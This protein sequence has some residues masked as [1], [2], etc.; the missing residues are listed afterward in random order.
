MKVDVGYLLRV[1]YFQTRTTKIHKFN[2]HHHLF[3]HGLPCR[4]QLWQVQLV[5][6]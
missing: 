6:Q 1:M 4:G 5:S 3:S 2:I